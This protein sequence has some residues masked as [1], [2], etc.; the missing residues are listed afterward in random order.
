[1]SADQ[2]LDLIDQSTMLVDGRYDLL[3]FFFVDHDP[4]FHPITSTQ[5]YSIQD[6]ALGKKHTHRY[7]KR[8]QR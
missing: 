8:H 4:E 3:I 5:Q 7:K 6:A 1:V 2:R